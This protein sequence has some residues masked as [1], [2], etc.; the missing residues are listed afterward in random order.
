MIASVCVNLAT[1]DKIELNTA[2][3]HSSD[4]GGCWAAVSIGGV[5]LSVHGTPEQLDAVADAFGA[6]ARQLREDERAYMKAKRAPVT[7]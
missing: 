4:I 2:Y 5:L 7:F 1:E 3:W 6:A